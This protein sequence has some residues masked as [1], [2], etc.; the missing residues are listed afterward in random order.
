MLLV[1]VNV[2]RPQRLVLGGRVRRTA[3]AKQPVDGP[4]AV[5]ALGL[6]GDEVGSTKH[7]G[8]RDQAVYV[9]SLDD[10][11]WWAGELGRALAPATFGENLTVQGLRSGEL[12]VGDRLQVGQA[13]EL[14]VTA[15][16]IPC[17]TL[18]GRMADP[19]FV[20]RFAAAERPGAYARVLRTGRVRV[21]DVV[22]LR[23]ASGPS[24]PLV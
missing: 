7:H 20:K 16:R 13:V 3:I 22:Q 12:A 21:G 8:G 18:A 19:G 6:D 23:P 5:G 4:V 2:A 24:L 10:Y 17:Q 15:P 14:E 9:Y 1:S 11:A